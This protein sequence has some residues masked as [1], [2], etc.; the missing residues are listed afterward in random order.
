MA[1]DTRQA[2]ARTPPQPTRGGARASRAT[3]PHLVPS[4][5]E[6]TA[7]NFNLRATVAEVRKRFPIKSTVGKCSAGDFFSP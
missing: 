6:I 7:S 5:H 2:L 4:D 3:M 1:R